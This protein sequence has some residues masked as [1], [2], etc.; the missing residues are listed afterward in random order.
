MRELAGITG[1]SQG[2][3]S[4]L[5]NGRQ[6]FRSETLIRIAEALGVE[7]CRLLLPAGGTEREP[8][9]SSLGGELLKALRDPGFVSLLED[10]AAAYRGSPAKF[11]AI[12][13]VI[14]IMLGNKELRG[15]R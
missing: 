10:M 4:R 15:E 13:S 6:D 7:P 5:E 11:R 8:A 3:M 2:Q 12:S 14:G 9:V 1:L